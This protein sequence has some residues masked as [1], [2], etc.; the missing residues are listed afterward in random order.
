MTRPRCPTLLKAGKLPQGTQKS[1]GTMRKFTLAETIE[2]A[3]A[4]VKPLKRRKNQKGKIIAIG[5]F[6]GGVTKT[7]TAMNLAQGLAL[8]RCRRVLHVDLDPQGSS[9][10]LYGINPNAEVEASQTVLPVIEKIQDDLRYAPMKTYW[11]NLDLIPASSD[12]FNAEFLLPAQVHQ[13]RPILPVL[14]G[15]P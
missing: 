2:W 3:D 11:D 4:C 13:G 1:K 15:A 12:L 7:S 8:R 6:K 14:G 5:N 10:T 9:T